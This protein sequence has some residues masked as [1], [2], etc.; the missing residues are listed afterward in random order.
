MIKLLCIVKTLINYSMR[1]QLINPVGLLLLLLL[2][3][4]SS[5]YSQTA[6]T[7]SFSVVTTAPSGTYGTKHIMAIWIENSSP[8][9]V[10]TKI[11]YSKTS[12][13]DHLAT[14]TSKSGGNLVDATTGATLATHGLVS[15]LWNGT[16]VSG[17]VVPDGAYK[18]W[19]EMAWDA[20]LTTGKTITSYS[21]TKGP[22]SF[23][24]APANTANFLGVNLAWTPSTPTSIENDMQNDDIKVYPNPTSGL[25]NIDFKKSALACNVLINNNAG[26]QVYKEVMA[27]VP[28]GIKSL[29]LSLLAPGAYYVT[30][31]MPGKVV[32]FMIIRKK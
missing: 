17:V 22:S 23:T 21:F 29:D 2:I 16:D 13:W 6:G 28:V 18:V 26:V 24:A 31:Q 30:L 5:L 27:D 14:W 32:T 10:K 25:L 20:N 15:F 12:N 3:T 7:F 1:K 11:M 9:F 19:V 4:G 8:T